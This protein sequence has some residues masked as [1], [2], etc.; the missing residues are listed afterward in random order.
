MS[1][2]IERVARA[3]CRQ[4]M[5][6]DGYSIEQADHAADSPD[7]MWRNFRDA[8]RAAIEAMRVPTADMLFG[9]PCQTADGKSYMAPV[10]EIW[11]KM[12]DAA[13]KG[14]PSAP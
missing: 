7:G 6:D 5:I 1:G 2:M 9:E 13:L 8:A 14:T 4:Y 12:I 10:M 11:P 3:L